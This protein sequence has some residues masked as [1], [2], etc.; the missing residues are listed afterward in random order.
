MKFKTSI[1]P[2]VITSLL[3]G[4]G[5]ALAA[6][7]A[8]E[9]AKLKTSLTP[10]GA[11]REGNGSDI[12]A[13]DGGI[14]Q[15]P[16][17]YQ[18]EGPVLVDPY[19]SDE[20][21]YT[22]T[23]SNYAEY[24]DYLSDGQRKM[25]E[26]YPDFRMDVYPTRRSAPVPEWVAENTYQ[27]ALNAKL[28]ESGL[29]V[30]NAFGGIPFP[31]PKSGLEVIWNHNLRWAGQGKETKYINHS[32]YA[33][34]S[35]SESS[36]HLREYYPYYNKS[37]GKEAFDGNL[38]KLFLEYTA[39]VRRKGEVIMLIDPINQA[40]TPRQAWQYIPGQRRV[41]RAPTLSFDTPNPSS[42]GMS[43]YDDAF[44][45][46]G[47]PERYDWKLLGKQELLVPYNSYKLINA[48]AEGVSKEELFPV[49]FINPDYERWEKHR[50]WVIEANLKE[51]QR[52]V[53]AKRRFYLDED[54]WTVLISDS[55]D[56]RGEFWRFNYGH[57]I[58]FYD[59]GALA[60]RSIAQH[61]ILSGDYTIL[62]YDT[63]RYKTQGPSDDD[64]Y[65]PQSI[66]Q[67]ARR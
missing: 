6:V 15:V 21:L 34:G 56:G 66:R 1:L 17:G 33:N 48:L 19:A 58:T 7:S 2:F 37:S 27:N 55:F 30:D 54:S 25:F 46:N 9:A 12:P 26:K 67:Q 42:N 52:H 14:T 49:K 38:M 36:A 28:N 39:P 4:S 24:S 51:G 29:G 44:M 63:V 62:E 18:A 5:S 23:A 59:Q 3:M 47:S 53:Y 31:I 16:A 32:V 10:M 57:P 22:V 35:R 65:T 20:V 50:V 11:E 43:T 13:W 40:E 8:E 41:R 45:F 60:A 64:F 61:D